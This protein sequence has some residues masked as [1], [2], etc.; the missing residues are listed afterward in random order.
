MVTALRKAIAQKEWIVVTGWKPHF[1]W[2][3]FDIKM[4]DDPKKAF[5]ID[6]IDIVSRK[7][8]TKDKPELAAFF[9]NFKLNEPMFN[10]LM[11]E[12]AKDKDPDVGAKR[13]YEKYKDTLG[14][15]VVEKKNQK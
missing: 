5:P 12:V 13:F 9:K 8:F 1:M 4:L 11:E 3:S 14:S 15:W 2:S 10:E 6:S 7:G